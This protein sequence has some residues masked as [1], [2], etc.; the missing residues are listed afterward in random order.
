MR[1]LILGKNGQLGWELERALAPLGPVI[2]LD[3]SQCDLAEPRAIPTVL[4]RYPA[5]VVLNAAAY[6]AVDLAESEP[7]LARTV[8]AEAAGAL[9]VHARDSGQILIHYSTDYVFDGDLRRLYTEADPPR[10]ISV[11]GRTKLEGE[12]AVRKAAGTHL[13]LRTSWLYGLR[14]TSFVTRVLEWART[15]PEVRIAEDQVGSPTWCRTLAQ[16]TAHILAPA[17]DLRARLARRSGVYHVACMGAASRWQWACEILRLDPKPSEQRVGPRSVRRALSREFPAPAARPA[18][19]A[20][21]STLF[22]RQFGFL[23]PPWQE[24]LGAAMRTD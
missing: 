6:N 4:R 20:L 17:G 5:D 22:Q 12:E 11:Y 3:R 18:F 7:D 13:I 8:N 23:L 21:D 19:S 2:A 1:S 10:P 15:R 24:A 16:A 14:R 9:A